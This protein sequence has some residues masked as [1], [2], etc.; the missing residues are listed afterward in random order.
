MLQPLPASRWNRRLAAG[1]LHRAGFGASPSTLDEW[2]ALGPQRAVARLIDGLVAPLPPEAPPECLGPEPERRPRRQLQAAAAGAAPAELLRIGQGATMARRGVLELVRREWLARMGN[3][4]APLREKMV[5]FWHGH[6][7]VQESID[8]PYA[9]WGLNDVLRRHAGGLFRTLCLEVARTPAMLRYLD[10]A[11]NRREGPNENFARELLELFTL[12]EGHYTESDIREAARALTGWTIARDRWV[13]VED[14][15][16]HDEGGKT[17]LGHAGP[18]DG[19]DVIG[20]VTRHPA[21]A[22]RIVGKLWTFLAGRDPEPAVI[23]ALAEVFVATDGSVAAVLEELLRSEAFYDE[24]GRGARIKS[25]V[26]WLVGAALALESPV[27]SGPTI[28]NGLGQLGQ[29]LFD[30]PSV[31]GWPSG[32]GWINTRTLPDRYRFA[33]VFLEEIPADRLRAVVG[34]ASDAASWGAL[35]RRLYPCHDPDAALALLEPVRNAV[36]SV[37]GDGD[38]AR[39]EIVFRLLANPLYQ[40]T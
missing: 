36:A 1:L 35:V 33:D 34:S 20:I 5:F 25:P 10:G 37:P 17:F 18:L 6:F 14:P 28:L 11:E 30:P 23:D 26:E 13:F 22:R 2:T 39:R 27:P 3:T 24:A 15:E 29:I 19:E 16:A 7:A 21:C 8:S 32:R 12:G 4:E 31:A 40:L 9:H 38:A